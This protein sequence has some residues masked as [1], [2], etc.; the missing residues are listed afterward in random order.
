MEVSENYTEDAYV[1]GID[2]KGF[3]MSI[4]K[5]AM[6]YGGYAPSREGLREEERRLSLGVSA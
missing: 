6:Q 3:F 5:P 4:Y 2:L 1:M